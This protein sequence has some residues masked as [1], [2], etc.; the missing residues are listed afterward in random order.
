MKKRI[1][2][3]AL[4]LC[5]MLTLIPAEAIAAEWKDIPPESDQPSTPDIGLGDSDSNPPTEESEPD[6]SQDT[7]T[8]R[9]GTNSGTCGDN[10]TWEL[11]DDG[12]LTISGTGDMDYY[13]VGS[14]PFAPWKPYISDIKSIIIEEGVTS[15]G[16]GAFYLNDRATSVTIPSTVTSI[17]NFAFEG[18]GLKSISI[19]DSVTYIG[20]E[21]FA[22]TG[23]TEITIP[24]GVMVI[25]RK[26]VV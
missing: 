15:I 16:G 4:C 12:T 20:I 19:P 3:V 14:G 13:Y 5:M 18:S 17:G 2:S 25:D 11:S 8:P 1:L 7:D 9:T 24:S 23:I 6:G 22:S 10:L 26:S 21:A